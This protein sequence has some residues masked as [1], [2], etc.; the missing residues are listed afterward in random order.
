VRYFSKLGRQYL[1]NFKLVRKKDFDINVLSAEIDS[2][3][4]DTPKYSILAHI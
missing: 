1:R 3:L 2:G 4:W